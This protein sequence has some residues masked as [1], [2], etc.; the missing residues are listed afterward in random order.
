[1]VI[2]KLVLVVAGN[3]L[4]LKG[5]YVN[6]PQGPFDVKPRLRSNLVRRSP[7]VAEAFGT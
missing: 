4:Y 2:Q 3:I 1:M 6:F 7:S 5:E